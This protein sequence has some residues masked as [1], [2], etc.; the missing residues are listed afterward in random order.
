MLLFCLKAI[1]AGF[2]IAMA[3]LCYSLIRWLNETKIKCNS[4]FNFIGSI[5]FSL[6]LVVICKFKL[7][8]F[9][10]K[11]GFIFTGC[12]SKVEDEG[13][14]DGEEERNGNDQEDEEGS[15]TTSTTSPPPPP[16][17]ITYTHLSLSLIINLLASF[18][19]G[20]LF[21]I[22]FKS[23]T[24]PTTTYLLLT[25]SKIT[26]S[27]N[28]P[29]YLFHTLLQSIY[30]GLFVHAAVISFKFNPLFTVFFI[31]AFVYNGFQHC[32][33]NAFYFGLT[34]YRHLSINMLINELV[35]IVGNVVGTIPLQLLMNHYHL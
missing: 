10:G 26:L 16:P 24:L 18:S 31:S 12:N 6:G 34:Y 22:I 27:P 20:I 14:E 9:T 25:Q 23:T 7:Y 30:C 8:L 4:I 1:L 29:E 19:I 3:G 33:A 32:I 15:S 21:A 13:G 5:V 11:V 2:S 17:Y 35:V 28:I